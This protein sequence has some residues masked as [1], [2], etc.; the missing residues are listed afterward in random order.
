[1]PAP[2]PAD[3]DPEPVGNLGGKARRPVDH[4]RE[5]VA[6]DAEDLVLGTDHPQE[7]TAHLP[8]DLV[9][10]GVSLLVIRALEPVEIEE[11]ERDGAVGRPS[12]RRKRAHELVEG[13][14]VRE[15][16]ERVTPRL[17]VRQRH[18]ALVRERGGREVCDRGH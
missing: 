5:L 13:A 12:L 17:R 8:Q 14:F 10:D 18:S 9:A 2:L 11:D 1:M 4:E 15:P 6:A 3:G 16:G 7:D